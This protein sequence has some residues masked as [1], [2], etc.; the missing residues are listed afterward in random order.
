MSR[1]PYRRLR[2]SRFMFPE[3]GI[4]EV[5]NIRSLH[6]GSATVQSSM[7]LDNP[8]DLVLSYSQ[9]MMAWLLFVDATPRQI[10]QIGLGGGSFARWLDK[11]IPE[12]R[13]RVVEINPQVIQVARNLFELPFED[14]HF[15]IIEADGVDY[16]RIL[17]GNDVDVILVDGFDGEQI[18]DG[19]VSESFFA[20]CRQALSPQGIF[21][22]NWWQGDQRY[23][24]FLRRLNKVFDNQVIVI[25]AKTHGNAAV[26]AFQSMPKY[27]NG[28]LL[29]KKAQLL[30]DTYQIDFSELLNLA[31]ADAHNQHLTWLRQS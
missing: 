5:D 21:V 1:F 22:T 28:R 3:V 12:S 27:Q 31:K 7:N 10:V 2:P 23:A 24:A 29:R 16:I 8:S 25:P 26:M 15:Q 18:I 14:E 17:K 4:S 13:Q 19:M 30:S 9:A 11:F 20:D 6:L